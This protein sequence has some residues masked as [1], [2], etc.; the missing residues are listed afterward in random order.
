V[1]KVPSLRNVAL[2]APYL[3]D[4]SVKS[5]DEMVKTMAKYQLGRTIPDDD[6]RLIVS[7]LESLT[8]EKL[9]KSTSEK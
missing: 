5:L 9:A 2:T 8:G 3:H 1:F 6:V 7:F 4:R